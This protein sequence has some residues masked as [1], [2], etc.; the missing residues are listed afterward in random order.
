MSVTTNKD[1][2]SKNNNLKLSKVNL[3]SLF[4]RRLQNFMITLYESILCELSTL[5][6][7][8]VH[9][10]VFIQQFARKSYHVPSQPK[11]NDIRSALFFILSQQNMELSPR[12]LQNIKFSRIQAGDLFHSRS[13]S[14]ISLCMHNVVYSL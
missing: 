10:T 13:T 6:K 7:R 14:Y 9:R 1:Q 8:Y 11:N 2:L 5:F 12:H 3:K 4:I